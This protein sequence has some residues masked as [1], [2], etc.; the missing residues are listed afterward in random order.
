MSTVSSHS[1]HERP[2]SIPPGFYKLPI[3]GNCPRCHHH[4]EAA[5]INV[6][7]PAESDRNTYV[8]CQNCHSRWLAFGSGNTSTI[9]LLSTQTD[10]PDAIIMEKD[11]RRALTDMVKYV[12]S[13]ASPTTLSSVPESPS[14]G[15]SREHSTR[16][17]NYNPTRSLP[18]T[19]P[20]EGHPEPPHQNHHD[21]TP[22]NV[23]YQTQTT[24][25]VCDG[26]ASDRPGS[27]TKMMLRRL[28]AKL[29][30]QF[31]ELKK[32]NQRKLAHLKRKPK[33]SPKAEGKLPMV[34]IQVPIDNV[35]VASANVRPSPTTPSQ[36]IVTEPPSTA[37]DS[38]SGH[39]ETSVTPLPPP[40]SGFDKQLLQ[41]M[42]SEQRFTR[43]KDHFSKF[44]DEVKD[45]STEKRVEWIRAQVTDFKFRYLDNPTQKRNGSIDTSDN[46][47]YPHWSLQSLPQRRHSVDPLLAGLGS[48]LQNFQPGPFYAFSIGSNGSATRLSQAPTAVNTADG[49][50][51]P[52]VVSLS[53]FSNQHQQLQRS[54]S[55]R[56]VSVLTARSRLRQSL[57]PDDFTSR[58]SIDSITSI[59]AVRGF[60]GSDGHSV[61]SVLF[62]P[63]N[64]AAPSIASRASTTV[65]NGHRLS[66]STPTP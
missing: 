61:T 13:V 56:P 46:S 52:S 31:L 60:V 19:T 1:T 32:F 7:F 58:R 5:T 36:Q 51:V 21:Q 44:R 62:T 26:N 9:S 41:G 22:P 16:S 35:P 25:L 54:R 59:G 57:G 38:T 11:F 29:K 14:Q 33:M 18:G 34:Q 23:D 39:S 65:L 15:P 43:F 28:K 42:T 47:T 64:G 30:D 63:P 2:V 40:T 49:P 50:P 12:T 20:T 45:M 4:H 55:P 10:G 17:R 37:A 3:H 24:D 53:D 27:H 48:H 66:S 6:R 8:N